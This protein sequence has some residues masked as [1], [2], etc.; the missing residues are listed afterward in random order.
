[1]FMRMWFSSDFNCRLTAPNDLLA[2]NT[3]ITYQEP[4]TTIFYNN[5]L[6]IVHFHK[7]VIKPSNLILTLFPMETGI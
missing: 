1:M 7:T 4:S 3:T 6:Q 2:S 5:V